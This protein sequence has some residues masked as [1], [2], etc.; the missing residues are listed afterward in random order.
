MAFRSGHGEQVLLL[1]EDVLDATFIVLRWKVRPQSEPVGAYVQS[2]ESV[3]KRQKP[4]VP[5]AMQM[6]AAKEKENTA[7]TRWNEMGIHRRDEHI[8]TGART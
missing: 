3:L 4:F 2:V 1:C 7:P 5:F 8:S 6:D